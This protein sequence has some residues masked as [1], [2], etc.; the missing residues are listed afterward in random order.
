MNKCSIWDNI[1][2]W[3]E[4]VTHYHLPTYLRSFMNVNE[5]LHQIWSDACLV[6]I[7]LA[8]RVSTNKQCKGIQFVRHVYF[9]KQQWSSS[10]LLHFTHIAL[11][12]RMQYVFPNEWLSTT[13]IHNRPILQR[14]RSRR[15]EGRRQWNEVEW[16]QLLFHLSLSWLY[17]WYVE[18]TS[19]RSGGNNPRLFPF[20][21][22]W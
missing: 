12:Y 5:C 4:Q 21:S 11:F 15:G 10:N 14:R 19:L 22:S 17:L 13:S 8:L 20:A 1:T 3:L 9:D 6:M 18:T 2:P 16:C 7:Y